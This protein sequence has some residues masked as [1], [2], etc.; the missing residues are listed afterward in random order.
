MEEADHLATKVSIMVDGRMRCCASPASL[1]ARYGTG[2]KLE[3]RA[4]D[5]SKVAEAARIIEQQLPHAKLEEQNGQSLRYTVARAPTPEEAEE[6]KEEGEVAA[7][8][9][10]VGDIF[11]TM[12]AAAAASGSEEMAVSQDS[13]EQIFLLFAK[14]AAESATMTAAPSILRFVPGPCYANYAK[15]F[16]WCLVSWFSVGITGLWAVLICPLLGGVLWILT[17]L[18]AAPWWLISPSTTPTPFPLHRVVCELFIIF[19]TPCGRELRGSLPKHEVR[20][21]Q[22][23]NV[24]WLLFVGLPLGVAH[25]ASGAAQCVLVNFIEAAMIEFALAHICVQLPFVPPTI[26][27]D[28][29]LDI[30]DV[31]LAS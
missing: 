3:L 31:E 20:Y 6:S 19:T 13:L 18:I 5:S 25:V 1:R 7:K 24:I 23:A 2:F 11:S 8:N 4:R 16:L 29:H 30:E 14:V 9:A 10:N 17:K 28:C 26:A 22:L 27:E 12:L 21:H 15:N